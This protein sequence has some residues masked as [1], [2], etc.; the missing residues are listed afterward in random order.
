M[1]IYLV[2]E[3]G[4]E[5]GFIILRERQERIIKAVLWVESFYLLGEGVSIN[6]ESGFVVY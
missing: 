6:H 2:V 4:E 1:H 3:R 5:G